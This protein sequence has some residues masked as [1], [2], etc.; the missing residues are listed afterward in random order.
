MSIWVEKYRSLK[1]F[2]IE[3]SR[4]RSILLYLFFVVISTVF[5]GFLTANERMERTVEIPLVVVNQSDSVRFLTTLPDTLVV[6]VKESGQYFIRRMFS[7]TPELEL[8]FN[9]FTD[10]KGTFSVSTPA[11]RKVMAKLLSTKQFTIEPESFFATYTDLHKTVGVVCD[12]EIRPAEQYVQ[13]GQIEITPDVVKVFADAEKLAR[14]SEV[15]TFH[16][17]A[18]DLKEPYKRQVTLKPIDG[19]VIEPNVIEVSVPIEPLYTYT[20]RVPIEVRN[21]P[22]NMQVVLF[23][24][25]ASVTYK[26]AASMKQ[27]VENEDFKLAVDFN[28]I[29]L[30]TEGNKVEVLKGET[31]GCINEIIKIDPDSV[32]YIIHH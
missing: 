26:T 8:D 1:N 13:S 28:T 25:S 31:P 12:I 27:H 3:S 23:P 14:I 19:V 29:D 20:K 17:K 32:E 18:A 2:K 5:W 4:T 11:L 16:V 24:A 21:V 22:S 10:G 6:T 9:E 7:R 30:T 15:Y